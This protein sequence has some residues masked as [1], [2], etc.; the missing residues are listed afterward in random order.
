MKRVKKYLS[1]NNLKIK[2]LGTEKYNHVGGKSFENDGTYLVDIFHVLGED[3]EFHIF[4]KT[5]GR[6]MYAIGYTLFCVCSD[7]FCSCK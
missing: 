3:D 2:K 1:D 6:S 7:T 4:S 5:T